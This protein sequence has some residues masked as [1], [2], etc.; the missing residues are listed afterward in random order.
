MTVHPDVVTMLADGVE[1]L[2][3]RGIN[4]FIISAATGATWHP[5]ARTKWLEQMLTVAEHYTLARESGVPVRVSRFER[6][7]LSPGRYRGV[8]GCRAGRNSM[9]VD[10][11]GGLHGCSKMIPL[12]QFDP[13]YRLGD[14]WSGITDHA[15]RAELTDITS[16]RRPSCA[17]CPNA[18][19]CA[20]GCPAVNWEAQGSIF[21]PSPETCA[22]TADFISVRDR[23][24]AILNGCP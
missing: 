9:S 6:S 10:V 21:A 19:E 3:E 15:A 16:L 4:Q 5:E 22:L 20:G 14:V 2:Q 8:F 12:N 7:E 23:F 13:P 11:D 1:Q 24:A 17:V 18:D